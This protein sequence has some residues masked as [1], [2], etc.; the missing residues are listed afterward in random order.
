M[1]NRRWVD[2]CA[3]WLDWSQ[4][5]L[6][7]VVRATSNAK[8]H[9]QPGPRAPSIA[10]HGWHM[11]RWADKYQSALPVWIDGRSDVEPS[12][13]IWVRDDVVGRWGLSK[14]ET[15]DFGG[16]GA[17]LDDEASAGLP[18][19]GGPA[20]LDYMEAAF[21]AFESKVRA[22]DDDTVL[23]IAITDLYGERSTI[24]DAIAD[25]TSH[26]E[27]HLGMIEALRGV[28]GDHGT[29]TV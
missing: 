25:A 14:I 6:L 8:L 19:P 1:V 2:F 22:I 27:R 21:T 26:S 12:D 20:L 29:V 24:A 5:N 28:L 10:F 7:A 16:T 4:H 23:D 13:E 11:A 18:L 9:A 17:G 3:D 15:G